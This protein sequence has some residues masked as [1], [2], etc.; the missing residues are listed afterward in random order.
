M[1][2]AK[3]GTKEQIGRAGTPAALRVGFILTHQFTLLPFAALVDAFRLAA[4]EG[5]GSRPIHCQWS[6]IAPSLDPIPASCGV[7]VRPNELFC[8]PTRFDYI[9]VV[10]GLL[11]IMPDRRTLDYIQTA[12]KA[13]VPLIGVGTGSFTLLRAGVL[14]GR[15]CCV[16]WYHYQNLIEEF[17][18]VIPVADQLFVVD[19]RYIT[20]AGG[21]VA[22]DLAYWLIARHVGP[23]L[24]Q[25]SL[26]IMIVDRAR[27]ATSPQPQPPLAYDIDD[28]RVLRAI[29]LIEQNLSEPLSLSAIATH[30]NISKRQL[31][32]LFRTH[33]GQGV[34][35]Y[36]RMLRVHYGLWQ[37]AIRER[38]ITEIAQ[39]CGFSDASHFIRSFRQEFGKSPLQMRRAGRAEI[40]RCLRGVK[41]KLP[42][43]L[44]EP[45]AMLG[46]KNDILVRERRPYFA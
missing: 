10:S 7:E 36:S 32:R 38:T 37:L 26:H 14:N 18:D 25:K 42:S 43:Q 19:G 16:S 27:P 5:D 15:R 3:T 20:C 13:G 22:I 30:L 41:Q 44:A 40:L 34:Q 1:R 29:L 39:D 6:I 17:T 33:V 35:T 2:R 46:S 8:D 31:E 21:A 9:I 23:A 28:A 24:A 12:D 4:D 11:K 45:G